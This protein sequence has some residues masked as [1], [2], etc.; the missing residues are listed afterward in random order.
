MKQNVGK[1][2]AVARI[3]LAAVIAI[4]GYYFKTWWG[5]LAVVPLLTGMFGFFPLYKLFGINTCKI[6]TQ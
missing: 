5:L 6:K 1:K 3:I 2:D 4:A